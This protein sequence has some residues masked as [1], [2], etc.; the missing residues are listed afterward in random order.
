LL[1][2][3]L[4]RIH[5][6]QIQTTTPNC[7]NEHTELLKA[8][9]DHF[10]S[11]GSIINKEAGQL[12]DSLS[13][14]SNAP[15]NTKEVSSS[16]SLQPCNPSQIKALMDTMS[17]FKG[18]GPDDICPKFYINNSQTLSIPI[19]HLINVIIST[20]VVPPRLKEAIIIPIP[21]G[22][23]AAD[24]SSYR[25]ISILNFLHK[26]F[27]KYVN[28]KLK[29][30][31]ISNCLLSDYQFGY[32]KYRN[33]TNPI[34]LL[35]DYVSFSLDDSLI[36]V[37]V[38]I[39]FR[40]A[41]DTCDH[42]KLLNRLIS[43][44]FHDT[45]IKLFGSYLD[46]RSNRVKFKGLL[47]EAFVTKTGVPQ[48]SILGP[49]LFIIYINELLTLNIKGRV[50]AYA[51]DLIYLNSDKCLTNLTYSTQEDLN[52]L[53]THFLDLG[54]VANMEKTVVISFAFNKLP[55]R[56]NL[57]LNKMPISF[58]TELKYLGLIISSSLSWNSYL[59]VLSQQLRKVICQL[60]ILKKILEPC[61]LRK[62]YYAFFYS[63][64]CCYIIF[65]GTTTKFN[66]G[67][68]QSLQSLAVR[69]L[70]GTSMEE[71]RRVGTTALYLNSKMQHVTQLFAQKIC[72]FLWDNDHLRPDKNSSTKHRQLKSLFKS[73]RTKK[74][75]TE[76]SMRSYA[77]RLLNTLSINFDFDTRQQFSNFIK[78]RIE[79]STTIGPRYAN[80]L[81]PP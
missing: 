63:R 23:N 50:F 9:T 11:I 38:S 43:M 80:F 4:S 71:H 25:P 21:K 33:I 17:K 58:V 74:A 28:F 19:S 10:S 36:P 45:M 12:R 26:L 73:V 72:L 18:P 7:I 68:L 6:A 30:Y 75:T 16:F 76:L 51:D 2:T 39:D 22:G 48:G 35:L 52:V 44:G 57:Q 42:V 54:L 37:A 78:T 64:L 55:P 59:K 32:I 79:G 69:I 29:S 60:H 67:R 40:K 5:L 31:L 3:L 81:R 14:N 15:S 70:S 77:P 24:P 62:I 53:Q 49:Y 66:L 13:L 1:G 8:I 61:W 65:W 20:G 27:E 56:I 41:F 47:G 34:A 46:N